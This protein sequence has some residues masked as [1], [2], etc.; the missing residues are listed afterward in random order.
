MSPQVL[1]V[2]AGGVGG[3]LLTGLVTLAS[4]ALGRRHEQRRWLLDRRLDAYAAFGAAVN[5]FQNGYRRRTI[6]PLLEVLNDA[7]TELANRGQQ[8][9]LL[10]PSDTG[11]YVDE[12]W[13]SARDGLG[14]LTFPQAYPN[15]DDE[16]AM[17]ELMKSYNQMLDLQKRDL[18]NRPRRHP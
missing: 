9:L 14:R 2:L 15:V 13:S 17:H 5:G 18:G 8:V 11:G 7:I 6:D 4:S 12:V 1:S 16:V 10:A 3:A